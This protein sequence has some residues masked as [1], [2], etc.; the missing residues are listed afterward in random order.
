MPSLKELFRPQAAWRFR[1]KNRPRSTYVF[2]ARVGGAKNEYRAAAAMASPAR[3]Q[4]N[5]S[6]IVLSDLAQLEGADD[7]DP[8]E[9]AAEMRSFV[10]TWFDVVRERSAT[11]SS[12]SSACSWLDGARRLDRQEQTD[13]ALDLLYD[14]VDELLRGGRFAELGRLLDAVQTAE[15]S[16]DLLLGLLTATLPARSRLPARAAFFERVQRTLQQRGELE[17]GLLTGLE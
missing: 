5:W 2:V 8:T 7:A 14:N 17:S 16:A 13:A 6:R 10:L 1:R 4:H 15:Y 11:A 9:P 12:A 3:F